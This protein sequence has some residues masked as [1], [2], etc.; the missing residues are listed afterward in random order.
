[1]VNY[2][3][4]MD[5]AAKNYSAEVSNCTGEK[6][7]NKFSEKMSADAAHREN[8]IHSQVT[9]PSCRRL[10]KYRVYNFNCHKGYKLVDT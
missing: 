3:T 1:M 5:I 2:E 4:C 6:D 7:I 9:C 8:L 10:I